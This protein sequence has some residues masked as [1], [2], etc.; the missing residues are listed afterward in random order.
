MSAVGA[1]PP[2][3][4]LRAGGP[5]V[6]RARHSAHSGDPCTQL[7][8]RAEVEVEA[9]ADC[10]RSKRRLERAFQS[11]RF[12][13][14]RN[15]PPSIAVG[16]AFPL[17]LPASSGE[18]E[19]ASERANQVNAS[20]NLGLLATIVAASALALFA[21]FRFRFRFNR[22]PAT[23]ATCARSASG[24]VSWLLVGA[25]ATRPEARR[26]GRSLEPT[27]ERRRSRTRGQLWPICSASSALRPINIDCTFPPT[28]TSRVDTRKGQANRRSD[29]QTIGASDSATSNRRQ[30]ASRALIG[31]D[32]GAPTRP[33]NELQ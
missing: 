3:R 17:P 18:S 24:R 33:S 5:L 2:S 27:D 32:V 6:G 21:R 16:F 29:S 20:A 19:R 13:S 12:G 28:Q 4:A 9:E 30:I 1:C 8:A 7:Q 23:S 31:L 15:S 10:A 26:V 22:R 11:V 25:P 14:L